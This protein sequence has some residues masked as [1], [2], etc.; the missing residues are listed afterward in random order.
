MPISLSGLDLAF[1]E[2]PDNRL[3]D[4]MKVRRKRQPRGPRSDCVASPYFMPDVDS[5]Y[6]GSWKSIIDG[7]E[8]SSRTNWR[9]HNRRNGV[10]QVDPDYWGKT[11]DDYVTENKERMGYDPSLIGHPDFQWKEPA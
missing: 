1:L 10:V 7:T 2:N 9:E 4:E 6:G 11:Q 3:P 8:I 5:A